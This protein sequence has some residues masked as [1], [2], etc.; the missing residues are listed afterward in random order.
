MGGELLFRHTA[1]GQGHPEVPVWQTFGIIDQHSQLSSQLPKFWD[2]TQ[3]FTHD[4]RVL[5]PPG[6]SPASSSQLGI[7]MPGSKCISFFYFP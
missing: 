4:R 5:H 1:N 3:G 7:I 2:G 6:S